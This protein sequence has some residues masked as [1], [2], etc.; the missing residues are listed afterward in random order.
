MTANQRKAKRRKNY[1][2]IEYDAEQQGKA[3]IAKAKNTPITPRLKKYY[4]VDG[5][6]FNTGQKRRQGGGLRWTQD[7]NRRPVAKP[8]QKRHGKQIDLKSK[9]VHEAI[10]R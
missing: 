5:Y 10:K 7:S 4:Y 1:N 8:V 2:P 6:K 9:A 3:I